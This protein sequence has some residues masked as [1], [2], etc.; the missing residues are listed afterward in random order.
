MIRLTNEEI[1]LTYDLIKEYHEKYLKRYGVKLPRLF[2]GNSYTKDALTLVY[3]AQGSRNQKPRMQR[4]D[5]T[6]SI[7][8]H[9]LCILISLMAN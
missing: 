1:K 5:T 8:L 3:L 6:R 2:N 9:L 7:G 4:S